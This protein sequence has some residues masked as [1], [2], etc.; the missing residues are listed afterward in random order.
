MRSSR[1]QGA[2]EKERAREGEGDKGKGRERERAGAPCW[3][4]WI[5][6]GAGD[7]RWGRGRAGRNPRSLS[8][9]IGFKLYG[10]FEFF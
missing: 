8:R 2:S 1:G 10:E 4:S 6:R 7:E 3:G 5:R 9:E